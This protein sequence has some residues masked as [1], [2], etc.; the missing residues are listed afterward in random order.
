MFY[1]GRRQGP[2]PV[3]PPFKGEASVLEVDHMA[4]VRAR[5]RPC[6]DMFPYVRLKGGGWGADETTTT[7][8]TTTTTAG[9][10]ARCEL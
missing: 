2:A 9:G 3:P 6:S 10:T 4:T 5:V 8:T 1:R 7:M